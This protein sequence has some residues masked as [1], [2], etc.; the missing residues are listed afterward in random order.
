L[1]IFYIPT[2]IL[3]SLACFNHTLESQEM[4]FLSIRFSFV[5]AN[6]ILYIINIFNVYELYMK[7]NRK[8]ITGYASMR[9]MHYYSVPQVLRREYNFISKHIILL[10]VHCCLLFLDRV[11]FNKRAD[12]FQCSCCR[13][14]IILNTCDALQLIHCLLCDMISSRYPHWVVT[15]NDII[16]YY[17]IENVLQ[18]YE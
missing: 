7:R 14:I 13:T 1:I 17:I 10:C 11:K 5:T 4:V 8:I 15:L 16:I 9:L 18:V 3:C 12:L 6:H 2:G